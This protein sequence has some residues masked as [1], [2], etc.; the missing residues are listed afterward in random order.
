MKIEGGQSSS[1]HSLKH[2]LRKHDN[3]T[4]AAFSWRKL[5]IWVGNNI[6]TDYNS[7]LAS[8]FMKVE[9]NLTIAG[10]DELIRE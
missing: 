3:P 4:A 7:P 8:I 1:A 5:C 2:F 6:E 10:A 9:V